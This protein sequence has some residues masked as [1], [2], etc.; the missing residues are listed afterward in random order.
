[1]GKKI[2]VITILF[3]IIFSL[4]SL[5][6]RADSGVTDVVLL[7]SGLSIIIPKQITLDGTTG[8]AEYQVLIS[9]N[10]ND[11]ESISVIPDT[12]FTMYESGNKEPVVAVVIQEQYTWEYTQ[13]ATVQMISD[14][15][16]GVIYALLTAGIW[17]GNFS[18]NVRITTRESDGSEDMSEISKVSNALPCSTAEDIFCEAIAK[19]CSEGAV[20][21]SI[22]A[23]GEVQKDDSVNAEN[24]ANE[25]LPGAIPEIISEII[26]APVSGSAISLEESDIPE[27]TDSL[28]NTVIQ[29]DIQE[30]EK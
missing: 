5:P 20:A 4:F 18:F 12:T 21:E 7:P 19:T 3:T 17:N 14:F 10:I 9:G 1:M 15:S 23:I 30:S 2:T 11:I 27:C 8:S 29:R 13:E 25:E 24:V 6:V 28:K 16:D 26:P 22:V